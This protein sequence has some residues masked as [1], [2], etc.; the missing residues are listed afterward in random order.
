[1]SSGVERKLLKARKLQKIGQG[2]Q[3]EAIYKG[4]LTKFPKNKRALDGYNQLRAGIAPNRFRLDEAPHEKL[5]QLSK[6]Y[7]AGRQQE[8]INQAKTGLRPC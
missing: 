6:M 2:K 3:A 7:S 5:Q 8:V 4:I 1:M